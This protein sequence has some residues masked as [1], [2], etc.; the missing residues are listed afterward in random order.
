[1]PVPA[2]NYLIEVTNQLRSNCT[3][4]FVLLT[5]ANEDQAFRL[6]DT[7]NDVFGDPP[8]VAH[9]DFSQ[10][11][12]KTSRFPSNVRFVRPHVN[13]KWGT[14]SLVHA[15]LLALR[16]L[17]EESAPDWFYLISGSDYPIKPRSAVEGDLQNSPYDVYI[18]L[19]KID[20]RR[21][22]EKVRTDTGG[23][24]SRSY[25]RLAYERYVGRSLPIPSWR[26]PFR[27][28]AALH[29][30]LLNPTL[31]RSLNPFTDDYFCYTGDQ[32]F[33]ANRRAA[34][35]LLSPENERIIKYFSGRFPP[36]EAVCSTIFGNSPNLR[37]SRESKHFICWEPGL[38]PRSLS[39]CDLPEILRSNAHFARKFAPG[40]P[41][42]DRID[43]QIGLR[44]VKL[45]A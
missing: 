30:R 18:R 45:R 17:Y 44:G 15:T 38:H 7:L 23:L 9:H 8:I 32:W 14:I 34:N 33:A 28:P 10:T 35:I 29:L 36:D 3:I 13:T 6:T 19:K 39:D 5:H 24:E 21:V 26:H 2:R 12:F 31:L 4:G 25:A 22:P 40:A 41:V 37:I 42:L 20:H 27:G 16:K 43:S 11:A 1:L